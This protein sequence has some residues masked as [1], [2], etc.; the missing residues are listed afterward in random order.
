[1]KKEHFHGLDS[2]RFFAAL[3]VFFTHVELVK[4]FTGYGTHWIVPDERITKF[5]AFESVWSKEVGWLSPLIAYSSAL[6][7]VF[8]FVLSGFL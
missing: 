2:L 7:V 3:A 6:G 8:F 1:M 4:K 5:T